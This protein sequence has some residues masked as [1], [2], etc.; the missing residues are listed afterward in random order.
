MNSFLVIL[1][2]YF[3]LVYV[4]CLHERG[5][6]VIIGLIMILNRSGPIPQRYLPGS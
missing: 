6:Q 5:Y 2:E 3:D 4:M 1:D